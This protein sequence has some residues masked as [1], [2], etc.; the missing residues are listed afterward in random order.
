MRSIARGRSAVGCSVLAD[1]AVIP[2]ALDSDTYRYVYQKPI[3]N[4]PVSNMHI[5]SKRPYG[6]NYAFVVVAV[7]FLSLLA[8]AGLRSAPGVL[9]LPLEQSFGWSR[10]VI[11]LAAAIG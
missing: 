8:A 11:S 4:V 3:W 9:I 7:I 1:L 5:A 2:F 10:D 6:Q